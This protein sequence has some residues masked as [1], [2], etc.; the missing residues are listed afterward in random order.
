M[1][2]EVRITDGNRTYLIQQ[3]KF[4]LASGY[5]HQQIAVLLGVS[6]RTLYRLRATFNTDLVLS[7]FGCPVC[8]HGNRK[9]VHFKCTELSYRFECTRCGASCRLPRSTWR[10]C[11]NVLFGNFEDEPQPGRRKKTVKSILD[12][13]KT[14]KPK[15]RSKVFKLS[16]KLLGEK[17]KEDKVELSLDLLIEVLIAAAQH[18]SPSHTNL[19]EIVNAVNTMSSLVEVEEMSIRSLI[20]TS[21]SLETPFQEREDTTAPPAMKAKVNARC[22]RGSTAFEDDLSLS[23]NA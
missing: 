10:E 11:D 3:S 17:L 12:M 22:F 1:Q 23:P 18:T 21:P 16:L 13:T 19:L 9:F 8:R 4:C 7:R 20:E 5:T 2:R 15:K 14:F 6:E